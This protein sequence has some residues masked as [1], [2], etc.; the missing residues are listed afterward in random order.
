MQSPI[1]YIKNPRDFAI[2]LVKKFRFLLADKIY[3]QLYYYFK[4]G[5]K[6][7]LKKPHTFNEKLQW[8]KLYDRNPEYT[9]MVDKIAVKEYV[10]SIIGNEYIIPTLQVWDSFEEIDFS[11]LPN[12]FVLKTSHGGGGGGVVVCKDKQKLDIRSAK[13]KINH[14]M[15]HSIY[16]SLGEWPY[17]DVKHQILA[18]QFVESSPELNDYKFFCFGG[19]VHFFK[20]D[21]GRFI[22]HHANYYDRNCNLVPFGEADLPPVFEHHVTIPDNIDDM[23]AIA[24]KLAKGRKFIRVDL[25]NVKGRIL[26]GELT[27][28][29]ASGFG[30]FTPEE[31]DAKLGELLSID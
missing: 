23:I 29:P 22:E 15:R 12:S 19:K 24:E 10:S 31:W 27:F 25:Y 7:N 8:L 14:S 20:I 26:F 28:F 18:E 17:K 13:E 21:F 16:K 9:K 11:A 6:L 3:L 5:E 30:R 1:E 4:M 2:G